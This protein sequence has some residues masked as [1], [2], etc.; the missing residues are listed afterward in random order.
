MQEEQKKPG[1]NLRPYSFNKHLLNLEYE[2][3]SKISY[4]QIIKFQRSFTEINPLLR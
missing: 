1:L 2:Q 4:K 3:N